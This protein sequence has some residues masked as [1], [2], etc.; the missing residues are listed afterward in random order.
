MRETK[1]IRNHVCHLSLES[2]DNGWHRM[3]QARHIKACT[4]MLA[5]L[6]ADGGWDTAVAD[7]RRAYADFDGNACT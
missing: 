3:R 7:R 1:S 5:G 6:E 2:G 4:V